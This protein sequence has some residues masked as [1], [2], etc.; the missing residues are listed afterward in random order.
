MFRYI[1]KRRR[2]RNQNAS[3]VKFCSVLIKKLNVSSN[4]V[5]FNE[6]ESEGRLTFEP[7]EVS[8]IISIN[9][10]DGKIYLLL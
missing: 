7:N 5:F 4:I 1:I 10:I 2:K 8:K 6:T 3:K 9:I